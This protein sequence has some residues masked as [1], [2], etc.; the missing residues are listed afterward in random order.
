MTGSLK[1]RDYPATSVQLA[2]ERCFR[3]GNTGR[4]T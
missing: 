4:I 3:D 1:L 2:C